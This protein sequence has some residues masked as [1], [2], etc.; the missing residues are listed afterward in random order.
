MLST[1][2]NNMTLTKQYH[3]HH[4]NHLSSSSCLFVIS[5]TVPWYQ[6]CR[7]DVWNSWHWTVN[8]LSICSTDGVPIRIT[9]QRLEI[10]K[11]KWFAPMKTQ[12][13][14]SI[15]CYDLW[16]TRGW[17][18]IIA[19]SFHKN[20]ISLHSE[21]DSNEIESRVTPYTNDDS[22]L[23]ALISNKN[24]RLVPQ[25]Y[26]PLHRHNCAVYDILDIA[27]HTLTTHSQCV[28]IHRTSKRRRTPTHLHWVL[29]FRKNVFRLKWSLCRWC[30]RTST[31][32]H[33]HTQT[34]STLCVRQW[35]AAAQQHS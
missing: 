17:T 13:H 34:R 9:Y 22:L 32:T 24:I 12:N 35:V 14:V 23:D 31:C 2:N 33:M 18:W 6:R 11:I 7:A 29:H 8:A 3:H 28:P 10:R 16:V 1:T 25:P 20:S 21:A 30:V 15:Y 27:S 4:H 26:R 19:T 5:L